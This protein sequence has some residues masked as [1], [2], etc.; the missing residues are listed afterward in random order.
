[1]KAVRA[2]GILDAAVGA[3]YAGMAGKDPE[4]NRARP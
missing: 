1:M 2:D 3:A 4:N